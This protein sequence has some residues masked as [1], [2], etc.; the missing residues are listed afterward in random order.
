MAHL[1]PSRAWSI[2]T[3]HSAYSS[4]SSSQ[5]TMAA[6]QNER[7]LSIASSDSTDTESLGKPEEEWRP[8]RQEIMVMATIAIISLMVALDA[9]IL[10]PVLPDL[11]TSLHGSTTDAFWAGSSYLLACAVFQPFIAALSDIFGRQQLLLASL[12]FFTAGS[13]LCSVAHNFT[14]LLAG[15]VLQGIGGGGIITMGQVIF[16]DIVPLRQRPKWF[17]LVL[18]SWAI[19]S[20]LGPLIGGLFVQYLSWRWTFYINFPFCF[21]GIIMVPLYIRLHTKT[22]TS[23]RAKLLQVDWLGGTLFIASLTSFLIGLSWAG[24]QFAWVSAPTLLPLALGS[25]GISLSLLYERHLA[26]N[27][28]LTPTLFHSPSAISAY[29]IAFTQGLIL[30]CALYYTPFY[31]MSVRLTTPT[32]SGLN[33]LPVTLLLLPASAI[34]SLLI[35]RTGHFRAFI[36]AGYAIT[37]LGTG[38]L[39]LLGQSTPPSIWIPIF[40][41]FGLGN[42]IVLSSVNFG[43]QAI[44][45]ASDHA[46]AASMY[47]FC[48]TLGMT[49]GVA[50]GGTVFQ[51]IM[52]T[53]LSSLHLSTKIAHNAE[54]FITVL[55]KLREDDPVREWALEAYVAGFRGVFGVIAGVSGMGLLVSFVIRRHGM[56]RIL[57]SKFGLGK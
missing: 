35:T 54:G 28:F 53:K 42:G 3:Q 18:A 34:V 17:S 4:L 16:A 40:V 30:Y 7:P 13:I 45:N 26:P 14:V 23:I 8:H 39:T 21:I 20:V 10:V 50:I 36:W 5:S 55:K 43:I 49:V 48:R 33:L 25:I 24:V 29:I 1:H 41:V 27:P 31:F 12:L 57:E 47:A 19:G 9:T 2:P 44:A 52:S 38:L 37:T 51:N 46:R 6:T 22:H 32:Q 15:R 56:D 11:A